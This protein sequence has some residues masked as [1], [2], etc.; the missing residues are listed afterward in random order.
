MKSAASRESDGAKPEACSWEALGSVCQSSL[1]AT[2]DWSEE[3]TSVRVGFMSGLVTPKAASE[4]PVATIATVLLLDPPMMKPPIMTSLPVSTS[5]R[6]EMFPRRSGLVVALKVAETVVAA[7]TV[8][9]QPAVLEHPPRDHPAKVKPEAAAA[10]S[11]TLVPEAKEA[12]QALPQ[13]MPAGDEV[14]V[15]EPES[16]TERVNWP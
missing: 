1:V 9:V 11:V 7:F 4:G 14:T 3:R 6:V 16:A 15:P 5:P 12:E 13:S 8:T 2:T 10:E